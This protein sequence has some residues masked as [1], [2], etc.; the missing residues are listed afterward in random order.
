MAGAQDRVED[1]SSLIGGKRGCGLR[2]SPPT[3]GEAQDRPPG[4]FPG[5]VPSSDGILLVDTR[6]SM[7]GIE[8]PLPISAA[9][10]RRATCSGKR[11]IVDIAQILSFRDDSVYCPGRVILPRPAALAQLSTK[12]IL[13][14]CA[15]R[16][17]ALDIS[18]CEPLQGFSVK[19]RFLPGR[20][21]LHAPS[22]CHTQVQI[23]VYCYTMR[24]LETIMR[25]T[26]IRS[27]GFCN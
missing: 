23:L 3:Y 12:I 17:I 1:L 20:F 2:A 8:T 5:F 18:K 21:S 26:E 9:Q 25:R 19:R 16:G 6:R 7:S 24:A 4:A 10:E 13:Q 11:L 27:R 22:L 14:F 15:R